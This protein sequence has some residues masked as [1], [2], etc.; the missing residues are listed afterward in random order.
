M[1]LLNDAL[2]KRKAEEQ[3]AL[4]CTA[5]TLFQSGRTQRLKKRYWIAAGCAAG[6]VLLAVGTWAWYDWSSGDTAGPL[7]MDSATAGSSEAA[8]ASVPSALPSPADAPAAPGPERSAPLSAATPTPEPTIAAVPA[9]E[10]AVARQRPV[11]TPAGAS[12]PTPSPR[13]QKI[14]ASKPATAPRPATESSHHDRPLTP[15]GRRISSEPLY[16]KARLYHRQARIAEAIGMYRE[17]LKIDPDHFDASLN[18][19]SAYLQT[20]AFSQAYVLAADLYHRA[21]A[22]P[23]VVLNLA[24]AQIGC[25]RSQEALPL[26]DQAATQPQA[27]LYEIYFHKGVAHRQLG[28]TEAAIVWYQKA[29]QLNPGDGRLLFNLAVAFDQQQAYD[30]AVNYYLK[31]L[32]AAGDLDTAGRRKIEQRVRALRADLAASAS[33]GTTK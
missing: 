22:N 6:I 9:Q 11:I 12:V 25:G 19:T 20:E 10:Q 24:A 21:P 13:P 1:S 30:P 28:Q 2:R 7:L 26:L 16:Q 31:Y 17:V 14:A 5:Q 33:G 4:Q 15:S 32:H 8:A 18:L 27:P 3:P 29:E 23:R